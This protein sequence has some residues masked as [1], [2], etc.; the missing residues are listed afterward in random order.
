MIIRLKYRPLNTVEN[1]LLNINCRAANRHVSPFR[2]G[3]GSESAAAPKY[4]A[5]T[6]AFANAIHAEGVEKILLQ[7]FHIKCHTGDVDACFHTAR[8]FPYT[9]FA[10][11]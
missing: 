5:I 9:T 10:K 3:F 1:T 6:G 8:S 11:I 2:I 4:R 7:I